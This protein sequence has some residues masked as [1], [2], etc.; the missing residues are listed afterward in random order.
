MRVLLPSPAL[1]PVS[2]PSGPPA[3]LARLLGSGGSALLRLLYPPRCL[4]CGARPTDDTAPL[5]RQC[6]NGLER[7]DPGV[8]AAE[9][10]RLP[11][12]TALNHGFALWYFD[13][14]G[15]LQQMQHALKYGNRPLYGRFA[16]RLLGD[17][18]DAAHPA[19]RLDALVPIP[20]HRA[21]RYERGYN[22]S[23]WLAE[24]VAETLGVAVRV[25]LLTRRRAT[26]SQARLSRTA[27]WQNV[28]N[29]FI[30]AKP[31]KIDGKRL[32]LI[33]D[34]LT[35]GA[36]AAAAARVLRNAGAEAVTLATL[37]LAR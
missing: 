25:D 29:A 1:M 15:A 16:G 12:A 35:T 7:A 28:A 26:R 11:D 5:C 13:K 6:L 14:E 4:G 36:T 3:A 18:W 37:A 30:V 24:G 17:A 31:E 8:V 2:L 10:A 27:R 34:V 33:D 19:H 20:L 21:R 9:L 32:L 22:Q 23:R